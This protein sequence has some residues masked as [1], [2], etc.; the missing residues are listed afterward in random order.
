[1]KYTVLFIIGF[2]CAILLVGCAYAETRKNSLSSLSTEELIRLLEEMKDNGLFPDVIRELETR[3]PAAAEAGPALARAMTY[4]RRDSII[5]SRPLITMGS[6]A[7]SAIPILLENLGNQRED[8][9]L[10]SAFVLGII[11]ESSQCA[12]PDLASLLWDQEPGVRSASA[13]AIQAITGEAL[14]ESTHELDPH[15]SGRCI[16]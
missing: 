14:V 10:D 5:A 9:R 15:L 16:S 2:T 11:G 12:V 1:M 8:V 7:K 6:T 13:A 4:N 3:G